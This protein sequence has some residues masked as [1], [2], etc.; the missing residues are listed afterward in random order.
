M[1]SSL[2]R[3]LLYRS[4]ALCL[5]VISGL[6]GHQQWQN[7]RAVII[8]TIASDLLGRSVSISDDVEIS[9]GFAF[10]LKVKELSVANPPWAGSAEFFY[11][12]QALFEIDA[13]AFFTDNLIKLNRV[14]LHRIKLDLQATEIGEKTWVFTD[15]T[16][17]SADSSSPDWL[18]LDW[19]V[20][21]S[22]ISYRDPDQHVIAELDAFTGRAVNDSA[23][24]GLS[25]S[26][27]IDTIPVYASGNLG[28]PDSLLSGKNIRTDLIGKWGELSLNL[29]GTVSDLSRLTHPDLSLQVTASDSHHLLTA[30]GI[31]EVDG[32]A[33]SLNARLATVGNTTNFQ[34][35]GNVGDLQLSSS[36][37]TPDSLS[38]ENLD[39]ALS[40]KGP[41]LFDAGAILDSLQFKPLP[42]SVDLNL[43]KRANLVDIYRGR[44]DLA[45]GSMMVTARFP[46]FPSLTDA[47]VEVSGKQFH[48]TII[49]PLLGTCSIPDEPMDWHIELTTDPSGR[50]TIDLNLQGQQH[51]A[52]LAGYFD[53]A[54]AENVSI[55][56]TGFKFSEIGTCFNVAYFPDA[57][58]N[59]SLVANGSGDQWQLSALNFQSPLLDVTTDLFVDLSNHDWALSG[60]LKMETKNIAKLVSSFGIQSDPLAPFSL[61]L[62]TEISGH[63]TDLY[64]EHVSVLANNSKGSFSGRLGDLRNLLG[65]DI[66]F[67]LAG[68]N[69][70]DFLIDPESTVQTT[71]PFSISGAVS[72]ADLGWSFTDLMVNIEQSTLEMK[73]IISDQPGFIGSNIRLQTE[74]RNL[75][76]IL[77]PWVTYP[78]PN[79]PFSLDL[80]LHYQSNQV[81]V[82]RLQGV[83][84]EHKFSGQLILDNPQDLSSTSGSF[85]LTGKQSNELFDILGLSSPLLDQIYSLNFDVTGSRE[86]VMIKNLSLQMGESD[87]KGDLSILPG[88]VPEVIA[89]LRTDNLY[90]P[91]LL[92]SLTTQEK[93]SD[94]AFSKNYFPNET[95]PFDLLNKANADI[96]YD[97]T[98][99]YVDESRP[100]R[101]SL[102]ATLKDGE[103]QT[104]R[105]EW[106][107]DITSGDAT[108]RISATEVPELNLD[109]TSS[110]IPMLWLFAGKPEQTSGTFYR[111]VFATRGK[112]TKELMSNLNGQI[113]FRGG[114]GNLKRQRLDYLFGDFIDVVR[115]SILA[116]NAPDHTVV[117]CT[118]G[119]ANI[120]NGTVLLNPG[121]VIRTLNLDLLASG[122]IDLRKEKPD[123]TINSRSRTGLGISA[124]KSIAPR[125]RVRGTLT[126]P[127]FSFDEKSTVL[128][129]SAAVLSGGL[130]I[131]AGGAWDRLITAA[132]DPCVTLIKDAESSPEFSPLL[133]HGS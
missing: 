32:G 122:S 125:T 22:I 130:S 41:S 48:P 97:I 77:G 42:F 37:T 101:L 23:P 10:D 66:S 117:K 104:D 131:L 34:I 3:P 17:E 61:S 64:V 72:A 60:P 4:L 111:G 11:A 1:R 119:A 88:R 112:H 120:T 90:I 63:L 36:G 75:E 128:S 15:L 45:E 107:G 53:G 14:E 82:K 57:P 87:I 70:R 56:L 78:V 83:F 81:N 43:K 27:T 50:R 105:L 89:R 62:A 71:L 65:L 55:N 115:R 46:E 30:L 118:A 35:D 28:T 49:Q 126:R 127:S 18:I 116:S 39:I 109:M 93:T 95:L 100:T 69:A 47:V 84:G 19:E 6:I 9:P 113:L 74:G 98:S 58:I 86:Q 67:E 85:S 99:A 5:L 16:D 21:N 33:M 92:P 103:F 129:G 54:V 20:S 102:S 24:I 38:F 76:T 68:D 110:R 12:E 52:K 132:S 44:M 124:I 2:S 25:L 96:Q 29:K 106:H 91:L 80:D 8:G 108:L 123:L 94:I 79:L 26:G 7:Q 114:G 73:G 13:F 59:L 133:P 121:I 51:Q 31:H 40:L